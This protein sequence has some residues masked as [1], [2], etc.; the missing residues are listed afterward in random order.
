VVQAALGVCL[1][2]LYQP[3]TDPQGDR[4]VRLQRCHGSR[5]PDTAGER[6]ARRRAQQA[7]TEPAVTGA[8]AYADDSGLTGPCGEA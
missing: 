3:A 1:D 5:Y 7:A 6:A 2:D 4:D 8:R